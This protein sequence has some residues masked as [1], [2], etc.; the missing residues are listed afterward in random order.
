MVHANHLQT[1]CPA[2]TS[3]HPECPCTTHWGSSCSRLKWMTCQDARI[4]GVRSRVTRGVTGSQSFAS[5]QAVRVQQLRSVHKQISVP[6]WLTKGAQSCKHDLVW[7]TKVPFNQ[8]HHYSRCCLND[9]ACETTWTH[10]A[11]Q[12]E[13]NFQHWFWSGFVLSC[14]FSPFWLADSVL[15]ESKWPWRVITHS[16]LLFYWKKCRLRERYKVWLYT[17]LT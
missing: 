17:F 3:A 16:K 12:E 2:K 13:E 7:K 6:H 9:P 14:R 1:I 4:T 15:P 8:P 11:K 5:T 10:M